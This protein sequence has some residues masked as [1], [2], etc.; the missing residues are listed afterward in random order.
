MLSSENGSS[1]STSCGPSSGCSVVCSSLP[2]VEQACF[3]P[4]FDRASSNMNFRDNI[5][6]EHDSDE[7]ALNHDSF[8][9]SHHDGLEVVVF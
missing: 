9:S 7:D 5:N 1:D 2:A 8:Y 6:V 3:A 4:G